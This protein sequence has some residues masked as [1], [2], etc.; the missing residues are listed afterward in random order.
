MT[1]ITFIDSSLRATRPTGLRGVP[2]AEELDDA[3]RVG[4]VAVYAFS[5]IAKLRVDQKPAAPGAAGSLEPSGAPEEIK[6]AFAR[7]PNGH[8]RLSILFPDAKAIGAKANDGATAAPKKATKPDPA[9]LEMMKKM[10]DGLKVD[11]TLEAGSTIVKTNSPYV[12]GNR[13]TLLQ[14]DF[15]QLLKDQDKLAELG[16]P[17][18]IEEAKAAL[19]NLQGVK[20]NLDRQLVVEFSGK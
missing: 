17:S 15:S 16:E 18:S 10:F 3:D 4:R 12:D 1:D 13:V 9:K 14:I 5:D 8:S 20:V 19:K 6:F 11:L 7:L 2:Q